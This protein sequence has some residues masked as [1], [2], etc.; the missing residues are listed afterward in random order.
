MGVREQPAGPFPA[1]QL[2]EHVRATLGCYYQ[3]FMLLARMTYHLERASSAP[4]DF[5]KYVN[6]K[7]PSRY[8]IE[9]MWSSVDSSRRAE[10]ESASEFERYRN[11]IGGL[12]LLPARENR[13]LGK[14]S[15]EKRREVYLRDNLLAASLH[16]NAYVRNPGFRAF[17]AEAQLEFQPIENFDRAALDARHALYGRLCEH[18]WSPARIKSPHAADSP[19]DIAA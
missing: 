13:S 8:D 16:P 2:D 15:Y 7:L 5:S 12:L 6:R 18:I 1:D 11:R 14:D 17:C 10:F 4:T 9:H 19:T 3:V